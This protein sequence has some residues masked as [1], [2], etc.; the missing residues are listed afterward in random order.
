VWPYAYLIYLFRRIVADDIVTGVDEEYVFWLE[1]SV[2]E[3]IIM[4]KFNRIAK[5]IR[6][7]PH[8]F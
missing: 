1:I 8:L 2:S 7:V 5:L 3:L 4:E 6:D